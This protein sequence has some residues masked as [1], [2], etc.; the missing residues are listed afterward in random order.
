MNDNWICRSKPSKRNT[1]DY[2][3]MY[4]SRYSESE[5]LKYEQELKRVENNREKY[6]TV[7]SGVNYK[8][9]RPIYVGGPTYKRL[10]KELQCIGCK[11]RKNNYKF[12][13]I[14]HCF[15]HIAQ[16]MRSQS[17]EEYLAETIKLKSEA[18]QIE[19][20]ERKAAIRYNAQVDEVKS[21]IALLKNWDDFVEFEG[22][23]YGMPPKKGHFTHDCDGPFEQY[24]TSCSCNS[25][26]NWGHCNSPTIHV[27]RCVKCGY[28][29]KE[30]REGYNCYSS[31]GPGGR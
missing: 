25:C 17:K 30:R 11:R 28:Q 31:M 4:K 10:I 7:L 13:C 2:S 12:E 24:T 27:T 29:T 23:K 22:V 1:Q 26:E 15:Y 14:G 3:W 21:R 9:G 5:I 18:E 6:D 8:T 16:N 19:L 20:E